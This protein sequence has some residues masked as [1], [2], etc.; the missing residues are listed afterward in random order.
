MKRLPFATL[1]L[2][3]AILLAYAIELDGGGMPICERL[4][5]VPDRFLRTG[6]IIPLLAY[7]LLHDPSSTV[8]LVGNVVLLGLFGALVER[9]L[10]GPCML[11]VF[12]IS[13]IAGALGHLLLAPGATEPLVGCSGCVFA[14]LAIAAALEPRTR[15]FTA[16]LFTA[17]LVALVHPSPWLVPAGTSI[18]CH[19][20]GFCLGTL[21]VLLVQA[22]SVLCAAA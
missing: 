6:N 3:S 20:G 12:F 14:L 15:A 1:A 19:V 2:V 10:G 5:F 7:S 9:Q 4:G 21:F 16:L 17:N 13:G 11:A 22:R 8:H 18:G